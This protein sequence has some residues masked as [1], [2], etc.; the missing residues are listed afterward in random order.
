MLISAAKWVLR[1]KL[2]GRFCCIYRICVYSYRLAWRGCYC[3]LVQQQ[4]CGVS[5][6]WQAWAG[7]TSSLGCGMLSPE[8][9]HTHWRVNTRSTLACSVHGHWFQLPVDPLFSFHFTFSAH[10][11]GRADG[12]AHA[13]EGRTSVSSASVKGLRLRLQAE[14][15]RGGW[16][17]SDA[18]RWTAIFNRTALVGL[19]TPKACR[20][21]GWCNKQMEKGRSEM[22][23]NRDETLLASVRL[24]TVIWFLYSQMFSVETSARTEASM[25]DKM[26]IHRNKDTFRHAEMKKEGVCYTITNHD[27]IQGNKPVCNNIVF[28]QRWLE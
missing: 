12:W 14:P 4:G 25:Q 23:W 3:P 22:W 11:F 6:I 15:G 24:V 16:W 7:T 2:A 8:W 13:E 10:L 19:W 5:E 21:W 20:M 9:T 17:W 28:L 18:R 26:N 1:G 27:A